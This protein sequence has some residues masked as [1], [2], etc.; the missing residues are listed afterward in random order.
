MRA[1]RAQDNFYL[2]GASGINLGVAEAC[3]ECGAT[4]G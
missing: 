2:L 4:V 1:G 3:A